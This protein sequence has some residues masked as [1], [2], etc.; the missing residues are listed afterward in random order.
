MPAE[1]FTSRPT[2]AARAAFPSQCRALAA[3]DMNPPEPSGLKAPAAR[4]GRNADSPAHFDASKKY[5]VL[6]ADPG[7][8]QGLWTDSWGYR[9]NEDY[10]PR[11]LRRVMIN[12]RD[13]RV[14]TEVH[15]RDHG[16]LGRKSLRRPDE[17]NGLRACKISVRGREPRGRGRRLLWRLH[18]DWIATHTGRFKALISTRRIRQ[19]RNVRRHRRTL[20][21]EHDMQGRRWT[22]PESY[23]KW[24][25]ST[26]AGDLSKYKTP[27]LVICGELDYACRIR[28]AWNFYCNA[29]A[30]RAVKTHRLSRRRSLDSKAAEQPALVTNPFPIGLAA[31]L[32]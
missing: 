3:L 22:N 32:E 18:V 17:G 15:R 26:Y 31:Y 4:G 25:P 24:S 14:R 11:P 19:A 6:L 13:R 27:T 9:W 8:P 1:I 2:A 23:H 7:G 10:L 29:K 16:R 21:R 30:K 20:V 12:P 28:R 5:P